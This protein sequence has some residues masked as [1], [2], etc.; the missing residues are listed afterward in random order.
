MI[1]KVIFEKLPKEKLIL[2]IKRWFFKNPRDN[3]LI[4]L[5]M[6]GR[7]LIIK[8]GIPINIHVR[9]LALAQMAQKEM[10]YRYRY[11][12][13]IQAVEAER[14]ISELFKKFIQI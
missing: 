13:P 11:Y 7:N 9:F 8:R 1:V 12:D 4:R 10:K 6:N 5:S 14:I 2:R 3:E